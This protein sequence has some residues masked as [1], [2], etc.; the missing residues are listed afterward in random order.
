MK[1][2]TPNLQLQRVEV[3][4]S[5]PN[6]SN[7]SKPP[8]RGKLLIGLHVDMEAVLYIYTYIYIHIYI[9]YL[10]VSISIYL[11]IYLYLL[12]NPP[13][14]ENPPPK[15]KKLR[16]SPPFQQQESSEKNKKPSIPPPSRW[17]VGSA[18][19]WPQRDRSC[20]GDV[21]P[22]GMENDPGG[23]KP[24]LT[25]GKHEEQTQEKQKLGNTHTHTH[26]KR[27]AS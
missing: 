3:G 17:M 16:P 2:T 11:Y 23:L 25:P 24:K 26:L 21:S 7:Q 15:K 13:P 18:E 8:I 12:E 20:R 9:S 22:R 5:T 14:P 1:E 6:Q 4:V 10:C 19:P 27:V